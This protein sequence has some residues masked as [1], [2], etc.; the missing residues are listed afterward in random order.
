MWLPEAVVAKK[1][2]CLMVLKCSKSLWN[3]VVHGWFMLVLG[4]RTLLF[5]FIWWSYGD[6]TLHHTLVFDIGCAVLTCLATEHL[7]LDF[8]LLILQQFA[9][10]DDYAVVCIYTFV[11]IY[12]SIDANHSIHPLCNH[13][14]PQF[15]HTAYKL[16][17]LCSI[18]FTA[19]IN[20]WQFCMMRWRR[21][22][23]LFLP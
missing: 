1:H 17:W 2:H 19:C 4:H 14:T 5:E 20:L 21:I 3:S 13:C 22:S 6:C 16:C 7:R 23:K 11:V 8:C 15:I 18:M 12:C 10:L 9:K